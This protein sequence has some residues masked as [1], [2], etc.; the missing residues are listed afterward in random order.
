MKRTYDQIST[1]GDDDYGANDDTQPMESFVEEKSISDQ[2][3][4]KKE[5]DEVDVFI[6]QLINSKNSVEIK[7]LLPALI[8]Y[9]SPTSENFIPKA[10]SSIP[11]SNLLLQHLTTVFSYVLNEL[12][13]ELN[14]IYDRDI[15]VLFI[16][17]ASALVCSNIS[18]EH[19]P[20]F[21][22]NINCWSE[23]VS[24]ISH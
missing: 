22:S 11:S 20:D 8:T 15:I 5:I 7:T 18:N 3:N 24:F 2:V 10:L 19:I 17:F 13:I 12:N 4:K 23:L 6:K 14:S 16:R 1:S 9:F 21:L